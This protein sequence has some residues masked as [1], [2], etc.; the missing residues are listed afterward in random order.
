MCGGLWAQVVAAGAGTHVVD[1]GEQIAL[2]VDTH[3]R[4]GVRC[5]ERLVVAFVDAHLHCAEGSL[6]ECLI[7]EHARRL[8]HAEHLT[9][10][11]REGGPTVAHRLCARCAVLFRVAREVGDGLAP[12]VDGAPMAEAVG[13]MYMHTRCTFLRGRSA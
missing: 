5:G 9:T 13:Y 6:R 2:R 7:G 3:D 10:R 8:E 4:V 12:L 1:L 11:V